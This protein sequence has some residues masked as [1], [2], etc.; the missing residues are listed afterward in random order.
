MFIKLL[1]KVIEGTETIKHHKQV[2]KKINKVAG[3][4]AY[5]SNEYGLSS[6]RLTI[7]LDQ[8]DG[9]YKQY[10]EEGKE[11]DT[12]I[13]FES[14]ET[15]VYFKDYPELI[16]NAQKRIDYYN[17]RIAKLEGELRKVTSFINR[18]VKVT[19]ATQALDD[20]MSQSMREAINWK[21]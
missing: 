12:Y 11:F 14:R 8:K 17:K 10:R 21:F 1:Q 7:W 16:E 3:G 20:E 9:I 5:L 18:A 13:Y 15:S 6:Q 19:E 4:N 2:T